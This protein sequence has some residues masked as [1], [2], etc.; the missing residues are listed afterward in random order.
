MQVFVEP[1]GFFLWQ[2]WQDR[3]SIRENERQR[4]TVKTKKEEK[5]A[6]EQEKNV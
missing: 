1:E 4:D 3:A 5:R 2:G 6:G